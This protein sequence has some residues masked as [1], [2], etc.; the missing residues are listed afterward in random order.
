[1]SEEA[2]KEHTKSAKQEENTEL[3]DEQLDEVAGGK[4]PDLSG[5]SSGA[6]IEDDP[7]SG[8]DGRSVTR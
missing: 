4:L 6:R 3:S 7:T 1:M 8:R 2:N 5:S